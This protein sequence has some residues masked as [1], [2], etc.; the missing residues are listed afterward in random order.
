MKDRV[1]SGMRP[2]GK[3]HLGHLI[4]ALNNWIALQDTYEC[5]YGIVDWHALTTDYADVTA[6]RGNVTEIA[7]DWLA[8]GIDPDRST[9]LI[10]S[11]VPAHAELHVLFSMI[12]PVPWLERVPSYKEQQQQLSNK[13]LSTYGFLGYPLLQA[14]DILVYRAKAVPV[15]EDQV[16]HIELT[17]EVARRFNNF[18]GVTFPEP[19]ALLTP[20]PR[21]LG[22][23]G[24]KM[25]KSYNN[26][27]YLSDSPKEIRAKAKTMITDPARTHRSIP[28]NP[29]V[30][31][32][33]DYHKIFTPA[34]KVSEIDRGCRTAALG[35]VDC[36]GILSGNL[37]QLT[38]PI[39]E[40][41]LGWE[42]RRNE[43]LDILYAGSTSARAVTEAV[44][45]DARS[46]M[47]INYGK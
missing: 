2:T 10:Q 3:L 20:T 15:G 39:Y 21:L 12:T 4:G 23:D 41:R 8:S 7:L 22:I 18:Y 6:L 5:Y 40:R 43:V 30:C 14:A 33:F 28:G 17:R 19:Q 34:E 24:R 44:M 42:G 46:A 37:I 27:I 31:N 11:R 32:V 9:L 47:N 36:K 45:Q 25:S 13:D 29:E 1:F 35:C 38:E 26:C 16:A